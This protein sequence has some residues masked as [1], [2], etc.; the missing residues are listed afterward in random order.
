MATSLSI[1]V[2]GSRSSRS[3][4]PVPA[5][6]QN[7]LRSVGKRNADACGRPSSW[8][9]RAPTAPQRG[10]R[11]SSAAIASSAPGRTRASGLMSA[12]CAGSGPAAA[13]AAIARLLAKAKP[14][15]TASGSGITQSPQPSAATVAAI[16]SADP[17][18]DPPSTTTTFSPGKAERAAASARTPSSVMSGVR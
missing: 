1:T 6:R 3:S 5:P 16:R 15:L 17:S 4:R 9:S 13:S 11:A 18:A 2:G 7:S 12:M 10:S 8:T 14:P